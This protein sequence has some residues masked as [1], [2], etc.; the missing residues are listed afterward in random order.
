[1]DNI[2]NILK[3]Q[4]FAMG[5]M[6]EDSNMMGLIFGFIMMTIMEQFLGVMPKIIELLKEFGNKYYE[7]KKQNYLPS[8]L[9][10]KEIKSNIIFN[11]R[12]NENEDE[13]TDAIIDYMCKQN[14]V[15]KLIFS[16][17]FILNNTEPF[18]I[19][20]D[21]YGKL[22]NIEYDTEKNI[23]DIIFEI[24][25]EELSLSELRKW[26][27]N[28]IHLYQIQKKNN[29][30]DKKY[31]FNELPQNLPHDLNTGE[32]RFESAAS[33]L[34]FTMSEFH[35]NKQLSN[36]FGKH[37]DIIRERIDLFINQPEWYIKRGIPH[38]LGILLHGPPGTGK[39]SL[40]KAI[41]KDTDRHIINISLRECSTQTQL[42]N[43][44]FNENLTI[45]DNKTN[46]NIIIPLE[47]RLYVIEDIDCLTNIVIDRKILE[48][49]KEK[50]KE[51]K[52]DDTVK[53][54]FISQPSQL[55]QPSQSFESQQIS[56][57]NMSNMPSISSKENSLDKLFQQSLTGND[58]QKKSNKPKNKKNK[59]Q[60]SEQITLSFLLN[61]LDGVLETPGR[62]LI[63]TS[64]YPE[65]LDKA[66]IRP[67]RV[68]LSFNFGNA[69][70]YMIKEMFKHF[71]DNEMMN[72]EMLE[73]KIEKIDNKYTPAELINILCMNYKN[74]DKALKS[75]LSTPIED[76]NEVI[77]L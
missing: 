18:L 33:N 55:Y 60:N 59:I 30:G 39:T 21:I 67:G 34:V 41:A 36:V 6:K 50:E 73:K 40:I 62:I 42:R 58:N 54:S 72:I 46:V 76:E 61:L 65:K 68:D 74:S 17:K 11:R 13:T 44:F 4:M 45:L 25:S 43:L 77:I 47:Q 15:K 31:Y 22:N 57:F 24:Y 27:N 29:L 2:G 51:E 35:T 14:S 16:N 53:A 56:S 20:K 71:Y 69:D 19:S 10:T 38:T 37:I 5:A 1:M 52:K 7:S 48:K 12:Y 49:E 28:I 66:L 3:T 64:N 8:V 70:T 26:V 63:M 75:L 32:I 23:T 9:N